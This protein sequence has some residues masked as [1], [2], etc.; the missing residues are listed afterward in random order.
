MGLRCFLG[1]APAAPAGTD[2]EGS[3]RLA[4]A[5]ALPC[6]LFNYSDRIKYHRM[7]HAFREL[8]RTVEWGCF[9]EINRIPVEVL[10]VVATVVKYV[11]DAIAACSVPAYTGAKNQIVSAGTPSVKVGVFELMGNIVT[12]IPT[13]GFCITM[14][15]GYSGRE[16]FP[17]NVKSLFLSWALVGPNLK[18]TCDNMLM[19]EGF[20][21]RLVCPIDFVLV[22][23]HAAGSCKN[24]VADSCR[25]AR[26]RSRTEA[27]RQGSPCRVLW[28]QHL[29]FFYWQQQLRFFFLQQ[30]LRFFWQQQL[31]FYCAQRSTD[32]DIRVC[33]FR[34]NFFY[35]WIGCRLVITPLTNRC[36]TALAMGLRCFLG[37][38]PAAPAGT[39]KEGSSRSARALALP[40]Y[41]FNY[42]DRI[43]Y[44]R[45]A[46]A[47][48]ELQR[49]VEWGCFDEINRIPI[50][51][52]SVVATV[53][54]C[55]QD[56]I[57]ACSVPA[58]TGAKN[59]IVSAR[60][61]PVKVGVFELMGNIVTLIPTC[62][63]CITMSP[64]YSGRKGFPNNVK[65]LFLSWA[66][67]GPNLKITCDNMLMPGGFQ[68]RLVCL[69]DFVLDELTRQDRAKI[70]SLTLVD[71]HAGDLAPKLVDKEALAAFLW[72]QHLCF[73][74]W[75]QQLRFFFLQQP[76]RFFWQQQLCFY[77][78]Q[79]STDVD[80]RVCDFRRNFFYGWIGCRLVI[81]PLTN[82]CYTALAMGLRCFLGGAP[83]CAG[84]HR[85]GR[86]QPFS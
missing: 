27:C 2:K 78:A 19:P 47:F 20:Q 5:L 71:L 46:H 56:A 52:L 24:Y 39:D 26:R 33:D 62:G 49:T 38:A 17:N 84:G 74:Y 45:M 12:L 58:Y 85:Q 77:C 61:P 55:I 57:V 42:S 32:V 15:P 73:F 10:S 36:Y 30:P 43:K 11:Q 6:Y 69:I 3:S 82:R 53:V 54:K 65:S 25:F 41:L 40:C 76:L 4:R 9:D 29:C 37:G 81:T 59:Q 63:F 1:G 22:R 13:C 8:Q 31:C 35:G 80:I 28:Q 75:Q 79:R 68:K 16:G 50:E 60:T 18:I 70:M 21:K 86:K 66:L 44:H 34:R 83:R 64:G 48:R 7:A 14:S 67:V 23:T 72:Q 51:V